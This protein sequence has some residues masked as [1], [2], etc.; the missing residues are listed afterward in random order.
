M[1]SVVRNPWMWMAVRMSL[2][3]SVRTIGILLAKL[4]LG[5]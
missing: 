4:F 2:S 5:P 3:L 1:C